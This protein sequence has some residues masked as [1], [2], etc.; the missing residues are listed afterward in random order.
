MFTAKRFWIHTVWLLRILVAARISVVS[1][2]LGFYLFAE[3]DQAQNLLADTSWNSNVALA[4]LYWTVFLAA[5]AFIWAFPIHYAARRTLDDDAWMLPRRVRSGM[6]AAELRRFTE[7]VRAR[8][9]IAILCVPR[10]LGL[11]PFLA[12]L[13]GLHGAAGSV[14]HAALLPE[15]GQANRLII[16]LAAADVVTAILFYLMVATRRRWSRGLARRFEEVGR[17]RGYGGMGQRAL[18]FSAVASIVFSGVLVLIAYGNPVLISFWVPR[19]ALVPFLMG[20]LVLPFGLLSRWSQ[21]TGVP[22]MGLVIGLAIVV[23][24]SNVH[25]NDLRV[26]PGRG[27]FAVDTR[28]LDLDRAVSRWAEANGCT[29]GDTTRPCPPALIVAAEGGASRAAFAVGTIVGTILD[30]MPELGDPPDLTSPARRIFA[31]SGVSGGAFGAAT[32]QAALWDSLEKDDAPPC[33]YPHRTW[34]HSAVHP[35][36][37][38]FSWRE[39]LQ[40]L[41]SGDY[42]STAMIGIAFRDNFAPP[43]GT[44]WTLPDRAALLEQSWERHYDFVVNSG[45]TWLSS[46]SSCDGAARSGL[47]RRFGY[48]ADHPAL[49]RKP[50]AW[51]PLLFLNG[52]SV[53]TGRR[54]ITADLVPTVASADGLSRDPVYSQAYDLFEAMSSECPALGRDVKDQTCR[55]AGQG[56]AD[57]PALRDAPDLRLSTAAL[58]SA[59][60]PVIS[61]AGAIYAK[62]SRVFGDRL[63][64]GGFFENSGV[65]TALDIAKA[66][67]SR[68]V[69]PL[70]LWVLNEPQRS[71][72][73]VFVPPRPT[74]TPLVGEAASR[75]LSTR[76]LGILSAPFDT[77]INT[78]EGHSAEVTELASETV[79]R[80]S[81]P[82]GGY[83]PGFFKIGV[84]AIPD[85][86]R[87]DRPTPEE[88]RHCSAIWGKKLEMP[89]VSMSWWMSPTI[90]ADLDAQLC[91]ADNRTQLRTLLQRLRTRATFAGPT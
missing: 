35:A 84:F 20:T 82:S 83:D 54:I 39:C 23:T 43:L 61:P 81:N 42:L 65:S 72:T 67:E 34:Y 36:G 17:R 15:A 45:S 6:P 19:A 60:F 47:C 24:G 48:L 33:R 70:I 75:K 10:L 77:L 21:K 91:G 46:G 74:V 38:P 64:D 52:T 89:E 3:V 49:A 8:H 5:T 88:E 62:G 86:T 57:D 50:A 27:P 59:R 25:F 40:A 79:N 29:V 2:A 69:V 66:L 53:Q 11:V 30:D 9:R 63:V 78:R 13:A 68:H 76:V 31:L 12:V 32:I 80:F 90:Q 56:G 26:L 14:E 85:L 87:P 37:T 28:Q 22:L 44:G 58:T 73:P 55:T 1:A 51:L 16:S 7:A 4:V 18:G 41:T 71:G